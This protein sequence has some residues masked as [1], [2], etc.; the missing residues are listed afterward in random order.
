[1]NL[2]SRQI[3]SICAAILSVL[4]VSTAQLTDILGPTQAKSIVS[5]AGLANTVLSSVLAILTSQTG[6]VKSVQEMPGVEKITV[7]AQA[8]QTLA[9]MAV[10]PTNAKIEASPGSDAAVAKAAKNGT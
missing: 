8:N 6:L 2:N 10:E 1:M 3:L 9:S 7:N 5:I 4:A